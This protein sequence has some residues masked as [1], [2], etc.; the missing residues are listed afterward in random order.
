MTSVYYG[1]SI[2]THSHRCYIII[3]LKVRGYSRKVLS[4][5]WAGLLNLLKVQP[6]DF[7]S[8]VVGDVSPVQMS[9]ISQS[10]FIPLSEVLCSLISDMNADH[11]TVNQ[12]ALIAHMMKAHPGMTVPTQDILYNALGSLIKE[13]KIYHTGEGYFIVTPQTYFIT[14]NTV[15]EKN[16][17]STGENELPSSPPITYLVSN[18]NCLDMPGESTPLAHCKSCRCFTALSTAA[19]SVQDQVSISDCTGKSLKWPKEHKPSI[20]HQSTSTAADCQASEIS[21]STVTSRKD[22]EKGGRKFGLNLF[23]RS[24]AKKESKLKREYATFSGQF[25]PEEWPVRD[26][27]DL[28]N[29][30]RDLEHAIIKR[31]NPELTVDNLVRHTALMMKL[32]ERDC[33]RAVDKGISTEMLVSKP[34]NHSS[35]LAAKKTAS[36]NPRS[37]KRAQSSKDKHRM[38]SK[39]LE[40]PDD[41]EGHMDGITPSHPKPDLQTEEPGDHTDHAVLNARSLYKKRI[42]NPFHGVS[43]KETVPV[44]SSHREQRRRDGKN[45]TSGKRERT[46]H[47]SKSWDPHHTKGTAEEPEKPH[48]MKEGSC[49]HLHQRELAM[50]SLLDTNPV[51]EHTGEYS[52]VYPDSSTL[53]IDD[54]VRHL[55]ENSGRGKELR[56]DKDT[57]AE[58]KML[59]DVDL[60][61]ETDQRHHDKIIDYHS[62]VQETTDAPLSWPKPSVRRML[63]L[64][65]V[66]KEDSSHRPDLLASHQQA[67]SIADSQQLVSSPEQHRGSVV[68]ESDVYTEDDIRLYMKPEEID[69]DACSSLCLNE[70]C[71]VSSSG[72]MHHPSMNQYVKPQFG[73]G[74]WIN[75]LDAS[76]FYKEPLRVILRQ[77]DGGWNGSNAQLPQSESSISLRESMLRDGFQCL[78]EQLHKTIRVDKELTEPI[79]SSIFDYCQTSEIDSD[80]ETLHKSLDDLENLSALQVGDPQQSCHQSPFDTQQPGMPLS[81]NENHSS[82][83]GA[84]SGETTESQSNTGDSGIDSP[85][86]RISMTSSNSAILEGFK[87]RSFIQ[88]L[89]RLHSKSNGIHSQS[90]LL[91]LTPVMNV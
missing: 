1:V 81:S 54:K 68:T 31:I 69:E 80:A 64:R 49:E 41:M 37:K 57:D 53:R 16:W 66:E 29:L 43:S 38:K 18:E 4:L 36:K 51:K 32:E 39:A 88:N 2:K 62:L 77:E 86:T 9:P 60:R 34:R 21:K 20:H 22:K 5:T 44:T 91:Q 76:K 65:Q 12:E 17:W 70:D 73:G 87:R 67:G 82:P 35:K 83:N 14:N 25:P 30:P 15:K 10:Q 24:T 50:E 55:K 71:A 78:D 33:E 79:D 40:Y 59:K 8:H 7:V 11:V 84:H 23:R 47:R 52:S 56:E 6:C 85:R 27:N 3:K 75:S 13:R 72:A 45:H 90:S 89:E 74:N 42:D 26:E 63:S 28:N 48:A 61:H 19:P 58:H 46:S